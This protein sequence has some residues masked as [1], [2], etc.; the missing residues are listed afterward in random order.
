MKETEESC[1]WGEFRQT[2]PLQNIL[3]KK[4]GSE[5]ENQVSE[6]SHRRHRD[7][8]ESDA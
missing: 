8:E 4:K 6:N 1:H 7:L 2:T 5:A 3:E